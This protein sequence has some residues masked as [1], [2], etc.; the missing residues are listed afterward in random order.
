MNAEI[1]MKT[2]PS[3][4]AGDEPAPIPLSALHFSDFDVDL[5]RSE[6]RVSGK[7]VALRP[8]SFALLV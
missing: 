5:E 7:V 8:K 4:A 1:G 3:G 2:Q 6:L